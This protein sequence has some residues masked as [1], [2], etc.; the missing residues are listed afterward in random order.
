MAIV[1]RTE[2]EVNEAIRTRIKE[3]LKSL[4]TETDEEIRDILNEFID[5][6]QAILDS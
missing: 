6:L 1:A 5:R 3:H 2:A 4:E